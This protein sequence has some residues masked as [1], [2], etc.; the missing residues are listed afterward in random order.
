MTLPTVSSRRQFAFSLIELMVVLL[1]IAIMSAMIIPAMHGTYEDALLRSTA[2]RLIDVLNLANSRA[3]SL[4]QTFQVRL[5]TTE[6]TY[7][8]EPMKPLPGTPPPQFAPF[9]G[10][11]D[12]RISVALRRPVAANLEAEADDAARDAS[13]PAA[14][15]SFYPDGTADSRELVLRDRD[16]FQ[17][18]LRINPI[19]ARVRIVEQPRE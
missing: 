4:N 2:R 10:I 16:G 7:L 15:I 19:T 14:R 17:L 3:V 13:D 8:L 1:L 9:K 12:K 18:A 5:N 6:G 11:F